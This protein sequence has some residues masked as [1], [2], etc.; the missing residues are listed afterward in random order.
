MSARRVLRR[1]AAVL[2]VGGL[3]TVLA[4]PG[5]QAAT[6]PAA[7]AALASVSLPEAA[8]LGQ[9]VGA[10]DGVGTVLC[11]IAGGILGGGGI[12]GILGGIGLCSSAGSVIS[13]AVGDLFDA[14]VLNP[15]ASD[16]SGASD[17]ELQQLFSWWLE[18]P[19]VSVS[20]SDFGLD[21]P[22]MW[23]AEV[24][25]IILLMQQGVRMIMRRKGAPLMQAVEGLIKFAFM[26]AAGE[27]LLASLL[28]GG[29][30]MTTWILNTGFGCPASGCDNA[31]LAKGLT[32]GFS[33]SNAGTAALLEVVFGILLMLVGFIQ[34]V[35][36]IIR[37]SAIPI[38]A[39]MIPIAAAGQIGDG[40]PQ[41]WQGKLWG[42]MFGVILYKPIAAFVIAIGYREVTT[43]TGFRELITGFVTLTLSIFSLPSMVKLFAP[44]VG[45]A[46]G[47]AGGGG[48]LG[49]A[50]E[51]MMLK[52]MSGAGGGGGGGGGE[53][54][55]GGDS[56]GASAQAARMA[57]SGPA[58]EGATGAVESSGASAAGGGASATGGAAGAGS[59]AGGA[60]AAGSAA[61]GAGAASGGVAAGGAAAAGAALPPVAVALIAVKAA[62]AARQKA[63]NTISEWSQS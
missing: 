13:D 62:D 21:A 41:Q 38:Q 12:G 49:V 51:A 5:A 47:A 22:P 24:V 1:L 6:P 32:A 53:A 60:G 46:S 2:L 29:D 45:A 26:V 48:L 44:I 10:A 40:K 63:G 23:I 11:G 33:V 55:S 35:L 56:G 30:A 39:A 15:A 36:L 42:S 43:A 52:R 3:L 34:L 57:N 8:P 27:G 19:S 58:A 50:G 7:S 14:M 31:T 61:G 20:A 54:P 17:S 59:A 18:W 9:D 16:V 25:A 4:A 28:A 37:Q